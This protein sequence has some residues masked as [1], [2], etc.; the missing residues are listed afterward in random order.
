MQVQVQKRLLGKQ[1]VCRYQIRQNF[2]EL[3]TL[4][5]SSALH[6]YGTKRD[7]SHYNLFTIILNLFIFNRNT[8]YSILLELNVTRYTPLKYTR[9]NCINQTIKADTQIV[10]TIH[11]S[12]ETLVPIVTQFLDCPDQRDSTVHIHITKIINK[13]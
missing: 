3:R 1:A 6:F 7:L 5:P 4:S 13:N 11:K 8:R 12:V 10:L 9:N 2:T